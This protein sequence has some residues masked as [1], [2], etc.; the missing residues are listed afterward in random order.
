M[1]WTYSTRWNSAAAVRDHLR[2]SLKDA[3]NEVVKD[4]SVAFGRRYYAAVNYNGLTSLF[5]ALIDGTPVQGFGYKDMD[6]GMGPTEADCPVSVLDTLS[7]VEA[8][9]GP[10]KDD[11]AAKWATEYRARCRANA[12]IAKQQKTSARALKP[13]DKVWLKFSSQNPFTVSTVGKNFKGTFRVL[14]S[15]VNGNGPYKLPVARIERV[16]PR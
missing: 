6:E 4:A 10:V 1:G 5:V 13:G 14:A 11:G 8:I 2:Q 7:P 9:Y 12:A 3:G 15:D 16:E